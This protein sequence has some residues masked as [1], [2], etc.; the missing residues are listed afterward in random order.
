MFRFPNGTEKRHVNLGEG[1]RVLDQLI[2]RVPVVEGEWH[3]DVRRILSF[4]MRNRPYTTL[5]QRWVVYWRRHGQRRR[6]WWQLPVSIWSV[7]GKTPSRPL[8][9]IFCFGCSFIGVSS[10]ELGYSTSATDA[11]FIHLYCC[12]GRCNH[13]L[14]IPANAGATDHL[15]LSWSP[16]RLSRMSVQFVNSLSSGAANPTHAHD[17]GG[18]VHSHDHGGGEHGHAHEHLDH[19]GMY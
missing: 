5:V 13:V 16:H 15:E 19:P 3:V 18:V 14:R 12:S 11:R 17:H 9:L 6:Q 1:Q 7:S 4:Y 2:Q 8:D 10:S